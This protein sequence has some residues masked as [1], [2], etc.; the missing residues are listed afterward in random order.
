MYATVPVPP[1]PQSVNSSQAATPYGSAVAM[2]NGRRRP[3]EERTRS[4]HTPTSGWMTALQSV[5]TIMMRPA[6]AA[7]MPTTSV[8]K[9]RKRA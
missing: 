7:P 2:R 8:R 1:R 4:D 6:V 5:P 3:L 9:Y